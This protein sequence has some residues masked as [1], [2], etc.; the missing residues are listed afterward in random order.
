MKHGSVNNEIGII[1]LSGYMFSGKAAVSDL[2]REFDS[3]M[4]PDIHEEFDLI[5][6]P[7]GIADLMRAFESG[8]LISI[9]HAIRAYIMLIEKM[10][11]P[12]RGW[13]R[14]CRYNHDMEKKLPGL[15]RLTDEMI[16]SI[17]DDTWTMPW[18]YETTGLSC[19]M[20]TRKKIMARIFGVH[21]WPT[22]AFRLGN[23]DRFYPAIRKY[24]SDILLR[25]VTPS[26]RFV[27][28]HNAFEPY[29]PSSFFVLFDRVK[30]IVVDRDVRDIYMTASTYS[31]GFNDMPGI[32]GKISGAHDHE[33]F[34]RRQKA[35]RRLGRDPHHDVL[36]LYF[37]D[38]VEDY[39]TTVCKILNFIGLEESNHVRPR[40]SFNPDV[41]RKNL[42][43]WRHAN[44]DQMRA[45]E[46]IEKELPT[47]C[48]L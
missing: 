25:S 44:A 22:V 36:Y 27:V 15:M 26:T 5:R 43:L 31:H 21:S 46:Y 16:G 23:R 42:R 48:R 14:L 1:D 37:E 20:V 10:A 7:G 6:I 17:T 34:V 33:I 2:I 19:F 13:H 30:S 9:D 47:L 40:E 29:R 32:Y 41:S 45:I 11:K 28:T 18:P 39:Q 24:L 3:V 12:V 8:S 38:L 35:M 4:T